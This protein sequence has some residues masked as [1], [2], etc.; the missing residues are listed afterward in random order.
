MRKIGMNLG[1]KAGL[2]V[3]EYSEK[4]RAAGFEAVFTETPPIAECDEIGNAF[5]EFGLSWES[6]H[7]P[8]KGINNIWLDN[9]DGDEMYKRLISAVDICSKVRVPVTV[10]HLSSG[11]NPPSVNMIGTDR[12]AKIIDFAGEKG[13]TVAF[14]N[15][16]MMTNIVYAMERFSSCEN[17]GFCWDTGHENCFTPG[18][19][20]MPLFGDR[21][22]CTHIH[23]NNG[24]F[25]SD[26]HLIPFDGNIDFQSVADEIRASGYKGSVML[27]VFCE[28]SHRY[29]DMEYD[30]YFA[31]AAKAADRIRQMID[32]KA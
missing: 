30:S 5:C 31:K 25:N 22:V 12:F 9:L 4:M 3:R 28:N 23:D 26:E 32:R 1:A 18:W 13:V 27:E 19:H 2:S 10:M 15:Q 16:R 14:E 21:L 7:A 6:I 20:Y 24:V 17:V 8:F 29:D 11:M